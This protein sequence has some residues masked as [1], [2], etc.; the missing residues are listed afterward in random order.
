MFVP[1]KDEESPSVLIPQTSKMH[2]PEFS[3]LNS[4]SLGHSR[5]SH[6]TVYYS[7]NNRNS[8]VYG[9]Y[10]NVLAHSF[11]NLWILGL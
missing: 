3:N 7:G 1:K 10:W 6:F 5:H 2:C 11:Y 4:F 9:A 8:S